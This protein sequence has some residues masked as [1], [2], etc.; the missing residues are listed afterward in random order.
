MIYNISYYIN[1]HYF[2]DTQK[3]Y[4]ECIYFLATLNTNNNIKNTIINVENTIIDN[5]FSNVNNLSELHHY[6]INH[7]DNTN[8]DRFNMGIMSIIILM[9]VCLCYLDMRIRDSIPASTPAFDHNLY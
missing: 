1:N 2:I 5:N 7:S 3:Q 8:S 9:I 4:K 6:C